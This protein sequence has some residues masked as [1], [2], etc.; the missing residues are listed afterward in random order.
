MEERLGMIVV[1]IQELGEKLHG[2]LEDQ[3]NVEDVY[4]GQVKRNKE[5]LAVF[6]ADEDLQKAIESWVAK[7]EICKTIGS[8]GQGTDLRLESV[9]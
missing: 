2:F 4:R 6:T 9:I 3:E 8:M 7:R 5:A 1:S